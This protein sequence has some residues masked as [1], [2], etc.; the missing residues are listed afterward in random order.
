MNKWTIQVGKTYYWGH[1]IVTVTRFIRSSL[2]LTEA[3]GTTYI[4]PIAEFV[5]D[6][7]VPIDHKL[8]QHPQPNLIEIATPSAVKAALALQKHLEIAIKG[9]DL[10][11]ATSVQS[12]EY[13]SETTTLTERMN[14]KADS[15]KINRSTFWKQKRRYEKF[16]LIG[17][18]DG[19]AIL[20]R[21]N[22]RLGSNDIL[23]QAIVSV[24][25]NSGEESTLSRKILRERL[26]KE[27]EFRDAIA[28][29][30]PVSTLNRLINAIEKELGYQG[31][32]QQRQKRQLTPEKSF[33]QFRA[34]RPGQTVLFDTTPADFYARDEK[35]L[36]WQRVCLVLAFDVYTRSIVGWRFVPEDAK[37]IDAALLLY[38]IISPKYANKDWA[39]SAKLNYFGVPEE[40]WVYLI[41]SRVP[42]PPKATNK[43]MAGIPAVVPETIVIDHGKIFISRTLL[44]ICSKL[45]ISVQ[46]ARIRRPT[47]KSPIENVFRYINKNFSAH[48][49][50][51]K[52]SD[53]PSRG[54]DVENK[55]YYFI[56]ELD[57][58]FGEWVATDWQNHR[59]RTLIFPE[60]PEVHLT[61]NEMYAE[62]LQKSGILAF[63]TISYFDCLETEYRV[64]DKNGIVIDYLTY[65]SRDLNAYRDKKSNITSGAYAGKYAIKVDP[66]NRNEVYFYDDVVD[67]WLVI[68]WRGSRIFPKPFPDVTLAM[69]KGL[70]SERMSL[71]NA[72]DS[73]IARALKELY[74]KMEVNQFESER[75]RRAFGRAA[76]LVAQ[77]QEDQEAVEVK[78]KLLPPRLKFD[79]NADVMPST[80]SSKVERFDD[81][82][83][84]PYETIEAEESADD[85]LEIE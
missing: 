73:D 72:D 58:L 26:E 48:C 11:D 43:N 20:V 63:P 50:G 56:S 55:A 80:L 28:I 35:T 17:L 44:S 37:A 65:D 75:Q 57:E 19:R 34:T 3:G 59:S 53:V 46:R 14:A 8:D 47:D 82:I 27:L 2:L 5:N 52:G 6:N 4:V 1:L 36:K 74:A 30:P 76:A 25:Q 54:I 84:S 16:G 24:L 81:A 41:Q 9:I 7:P 40:V 49:P 22:L 21:R 79:D 78:A 31:T 60:V 66:R 18:V 42:K 85:T 70:V 45:G 83:W 62:G 23:Y 29:M 15:L 64:I 51:Y 69:A 71:K 67:E 77:S 10:S 68:P 61:P 33:G 32:A 12:D 39:G 13:D 38:R